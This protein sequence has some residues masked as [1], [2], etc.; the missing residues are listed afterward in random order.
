MKL[1]KIVATKVWHHR[2]H[3]FLASICDLKLLTW[4]PSLLTSSKNDVISAADESTLTHTRPSHSEMPQDC[5]PHRFD[6][7]NPQEPVLKTHS[8]IP[9]EQPHLASFMQLIASLCIHGPFS[10]IH[11]TGVKLSVLLDTI[12]ECPW[13]SV[14]SCQIR[15][16]NRL[17]LNLCRSV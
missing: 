6:H 15:C 7:R 17:P 13:M 3:R 8:L 12:G 1:C 9:T 10:R 16:F 14:S 11:K 5:R 4:C 2:F